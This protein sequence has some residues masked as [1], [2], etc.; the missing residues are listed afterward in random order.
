MHGFIFLL[1]L[2]CLVAGKAEGAPPPAAEQAKTTAQAIFQRFHDRVVM[3]EVK[4]IHQNA[5]SMSGTGFVVGHDGLLITNFHVANLVVWKPETYRMTYRKKDGGEGALTVRAVDVVHDLAL[6]QMSEGHDAPLSFRAEPMA[7]G[8]VGY[9]LGYPLDQG[10]TIIEGIFNGVSENFHIPHFHFTAPLNPGMSGGPAVS[11][12]GEVFGVNVAIDRQGQM[13]SF[14]V[15]ARYAVALLSRYRAMASGTTIDFKQ[16]ITRQITEHTREL[17]KN[18]LANTAP[19]TPFPENYRFAHLD[20][21]MFHC[22][23]I[24]EEQEEW[25]YQMD[26]YGCRLNGNIF[27]N[28]NIQSGSLNFSHGLLR[29]RGLNAYQFANLQNNHIF[30]DLGSGERE[31]VTPYEC[32]EGFVQLKGIRAKTS[33]CAREYRLLPGLYDVK[34][35]L[36]TVDD[37]TTALHSVMNLEGF[38]WESAM[39][40][41]EHFFATIERSE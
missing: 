29:N 5:S 37:G 33:L 38:P 40:L 36:L 27:I 35:Y 22:V 24:H 4:P 12:D 30:F 16:E 23:S 34:G 17:A 7:K 31:D 41:I 8:D 26:T 39:A 13:M 14:L 19:M 1:L 9:S 21:E 25:L 18:L 28:D 15:P 2:F 32:Q 3:I 6:V 11:S 10:S 20:K